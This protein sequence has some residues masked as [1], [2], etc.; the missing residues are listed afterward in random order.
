MKLIADSL[1]V[2]RSG[3][4]VIAG[5]SFAAEAGQC[6]VLTGP[7]GAGKTTLLRAI[8]GLL[9]LAAGRLRLE[10]G[11]SSGTI[12]EQCHYVGH[13]DAVRSALTVD[14]NARFWAHFLGEGPGKVADALAAFGLSDLDHIPALYLSA[15][16][17]RRMALIRLLLAHRPIWLLD[18]PTVSLDKAG[19]EALTAA[20]TRHMS[21]G[22][23]VVAAT[24]Q[25]LGWPAGHELQLMPLSRAA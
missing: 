4:Q 17:R 14:E 3:R 24:H 9:P 12:G 16:Q 23:L 19:Q 2:V 7:N 20:A 6:L 11:V 25:P 15:G 21:T 18:E 5:L 8:A 13:G 22:G 1:S 10:G